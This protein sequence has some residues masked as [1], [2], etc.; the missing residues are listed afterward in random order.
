MISSKCLTHQGGGLGSI[1]RVYTSPQ[2]CAEADDVAA[3]VGIAAS[4]RSHKCDCR[5]RVS[6]SKVYGGFPAVL[7]ATSPKMVIL[8]EAKK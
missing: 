6:S 7:M 4:W 5:D 8:R 3:N 2:P 1:C